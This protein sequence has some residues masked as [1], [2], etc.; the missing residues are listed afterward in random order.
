MSRTFRSASTVLVVSVLA[1][2]S[3]QALPLTSRASRADPERGD[4]LLALVDWI[5][6][7]LGKK[8]TD[9]SLPALSQP[10]EGSIMDPDG[11]H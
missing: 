7:L 3:L 10:K 2:G 6:S 5:D 8:G 4:V 1:C 11:Q 9:P